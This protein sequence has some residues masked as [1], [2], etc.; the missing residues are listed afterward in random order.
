M[1]NVKRTAAIAALLA[2]GFAAGWVRL[3]YYSDGPG[4]PRDVASLIH[5]DGPTRYDSAGRLVITTVQIR[6]LTPFDALLAGLDPTRRILSEA[7]VYGGVPIEQES[8][9][10]ANDI[11]ASK[12]AAVS[13]VLERLVGYPQAHG[14]GAL[15]AAVVPGCPAAGHLSPGDVIEAVD[16]REV[17]S[18]RAASRRLDE[19]AARLT[20]RVTD[21]GVT[22]VIELEREACLPDRPG[23]YLGVQLVEPFPFDLSISS[24]GVGGPS[25][26]LM[27]ALGLYDLLTPG[28][29]TGG[30]IVAGTGEIFNDGTVGPIGSIE[31]KVTSARR[32]G[33]DVFLMPA[34]NLEELQ[35]ADLGDM[36]LVAVGSFDEAISALE[37]RAG[38]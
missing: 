31:E 32:A 25:A 19:A 23:R 11:D 17:A 37:G 12:I 30:R 36:R 3:P 13:L 38:P 15:V 18:A 4:P 33:A 26:G 16:G 9:L 7:E 1:R 2:A 10:A 5:F 6:Q 28:D 20:I 14:R 24:G 35:D 27:Y 22:D 29:L 21:D 8:Q 34:A